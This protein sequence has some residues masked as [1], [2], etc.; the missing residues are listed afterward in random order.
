M[1]DR[2]SSAPR[3]FFRHAFGERRAIAL[4]ALLSASLLACTPST[5][6]GPASAPAQSAAP[7]A[8]QAAALPPLPPILPFDQAVLNAANGVFSA[9]SKMPAETP[10]GRTV[11]IDPLVDG[12]TGYES[13]ATQDI[14][15][16]ITGLVKND[17]PRFAVAPFSPGALKEA[18]LVLVGTFTPVNATNNQPNGPREAYRFCLVLGDLKTGKVVAKSVA[19]AQIGDVDATPT[20]FFRDSPVWSPDAATQAYIATCQATKVG[21]PIKQ[22]FLDGLLGASLV[23][24][25]GDAY[26]QG[27]YQDA[28]RLYAN[29]SETPAGDQ[30]KVYNGVYLANYK[31]GRRDNAAE[32][33]RNLVAYGFRNHRLAVKFLFEPNAAR[34]SPDVPMSGQYGLWLQQIAAEGARSTTCLEVTGHTSPSGSPALNER[35]SYLRADYV[36]SRLEAD[37]PSLH[38]R[39][40]AN[41]VGSRETLIGT[42]KDDASDVLDRRVELKLIPK[43]SAS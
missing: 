10:P 40:I 37:A 5:T 4:L 29:A 28:L 26:E 35:L 27:K 13:K 18:P 11:V 38:D 21:D 9:A 6:G 12:V 24:E 7:P 2:S 1:H 31:L 39:M 20:T 23:A 3:P 33:Y 25:A 14:Q 32:A 43:C 41:G 17:Y 15:G 8:P 22:E 19:R 34:F 42:G 36:K 30:L 16:R